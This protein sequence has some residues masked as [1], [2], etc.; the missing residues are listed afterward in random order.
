MQR[1]SKLALC[2]D[3][4]TPNGPRSYRP[5]VTSDRPRL[6]TPTSHEQAPQQ[7]VSCLRRHLLSHLLC[8]TLPFTYPSSPHEPPRL[9][10]HGVNRFRNP[11]ASSAPRTSISAVI[12]AYAQEIQKKPEPWYSAG[13]VDDSNIYEWEITI[14]GYPASPPQ[15]HSLACLQPPFIFNSSCIWVL[16]LGGLVQRTHYTK[17]AYLKR[18]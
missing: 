10:F 8:L 6:T 18:C 16:T 1:H 5:L 7:T 14:I 3:L 17:A 9:F 12:D 15:R 13:L 11:P 2:R 4:Q